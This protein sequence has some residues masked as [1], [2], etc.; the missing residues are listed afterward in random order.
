MT[1]KIPFGEEREA[2]SLSTGLMAAL[3][4]EV[5]ADDGYLARFLAHEYG[6][7]RVSVHESI[8]TR[9]W[10]D[11]TAEFIGGKHRH[12]KTITLNG[13][14]PAVLRPL[15]NEDGTYRAYTTIRPVF[16]HSAVARYFVSTAADAIA[17]SFAEKL[18]DHL[19]LKFGSPGTFGLDF[20]VVRKDPKMGGPTEIFGAI[21]YPWPATLESSKE[22]LDGEVFVLSMT[23]HWVA[24]MILRCMEGEDPFAGKEMLAEVRRCDAPTDRV[25]F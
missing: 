3:G 14:K 16:I 8:D 21:A 25:P 20:H 17:S 19:E 1:F 9:E 4:P 11:F 10:V 5:V 24:E 18:P 23:V 7:D 15:L 22:G 6:A 2:V 12:P 13:N